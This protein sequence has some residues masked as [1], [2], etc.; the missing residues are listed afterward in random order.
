MFLDLLPVQLD[1][2]RINQYYSEL[3]LTIILE[4]LMILEIVQAQEFPNTADKSKAPANTHL[5]CMHLK[6]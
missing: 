2:A 5:S 4:V 6:I 1:L 3:R